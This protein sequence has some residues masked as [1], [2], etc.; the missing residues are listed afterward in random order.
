MS[1]NETIK[2]L[3][4]NRVPE[5]EIR[6]Q[7]TAN[8]MR[9]LAEDCQRWVNSGQTTIEEKLRVTGTVQLD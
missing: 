4:H 9:S 1:T 3:I 2:E 8:G 5:S 7:A 6:K